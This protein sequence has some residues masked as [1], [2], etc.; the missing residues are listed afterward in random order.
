MS[1]KNSN[2]TFGNRTRDLPTCS[3]VPRELI[4]Y[5]KFEDK[6]SELGKSSM[7]V[8]AK[9]ND[10]FLGNYK[11]E[12]YGDVMPDLVQSYKMMEYNIYL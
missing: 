6:L 12:I 11:A 1:I 9:C 7:K 3:A 10:R 4:Q 8:I 2:D 5:M